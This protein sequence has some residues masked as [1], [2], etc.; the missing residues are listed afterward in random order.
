MFKRQNLIKLLTLFLIVAL[1][2]VLI[3]FVSTK[4]TANTSSGTTS[5]PYIELNNSIK[6][7]STSYYDGTKIFKLPE[8]V[9]GTDTI[10][11]IVQG[12]KEAL[13]DAYDK[14]SLD[15][16]FQE[17]IKTEQAQAVRDAIK[18]E[19]A[20]LE[21]TLRIKGISFDVGV[22]YDTL[23][24]GFEIL[25]KASDFEQTAR[26]LNGFATTI[27]GEVYKPAETT[28]V[29]NKVNVYET[30]IF[31][32]SKFEY[33]GTGMT[34]AV[35]DTG[36]DY[37]HTAFKNFNVS[38]DKL[39]LNFEQ[40]TDLLNAKDF[41]AEKLQAGLT[42][43]D[44]YVNDKIPYAFDYADG[45]SDVFPMNS[46][47]GTHVAGIIAGKDNTITGVA[48]NAQLVIMKTFSDVETSARSAWI[49]SALEDCVTLGV[50][51]INM[52]LGTDCGF[53]RARD[54]YF[55]EN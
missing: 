48:P 38:K 36:I 19:N 40:V 43:S 13:Y 14:A 26:T 46:D 45:D 51:V 6:V 25:I 8:T 47:H 54:E 4:E 29:E 21:A 3:Y 33:D 12:E 17:F 18:A 34:V 39:G 5:S 49:I 23:I 52:S 1:S 50:D 10:S 24:S 44:V 31:D 55:K 15:I 53:S 30:G 35:L 22:Q 28:L 20:D 16:T 7:N 9:K 32:S 41:A 37:T 42:A 27:V 11:V 2:L